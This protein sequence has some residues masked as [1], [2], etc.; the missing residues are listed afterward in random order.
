MVDTALERVEETVVDVPWD[1]QT[2]SEQ[3]ATL[4]RKGLFRIKE[5]LDAPLDLADTKRVSAIK[6]YPCR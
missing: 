6:D 1:Q 3:L 5:I 2:N 4:T